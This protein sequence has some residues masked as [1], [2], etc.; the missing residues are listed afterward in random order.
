MT[1]YGTQIHYFDHSLC[2][3]LNLLERPLPDNYTCFNAEYVAWETQSFLTMAK[4]MLK[5][6]VERTRLLVKCRAMETAM[7]QTDHFG[8][9]SFALLRQRLDGLRYKLSGECHQ[10]VDNLLLELSRLLNLNLTEEEYLQKWNQLKLRAS[11]FPS[12]VMPLVENELIDFYESQSP[13]EPTLIR[14]VLTTEDHDNLI[15]R[16][17]QYYCKRAGKEQ[18]VKVHDN[19]KKSQKPVEAQPRELMTFTLRGITD[20]HLTLLFMYMQ[21]EGWIKGTVGDF[22]ALFSGRRENVRLIWTGEMGKS[23]LEYLFQLMCNAPKGITL[24]K[25][26]TLTAILQGHFTDAQGEFLTGLGKGHLPNVKAAPIV[27]EWIDML[28]MGPDELMYYAKERLHDNRDDDMKRDVLE[29]FDI[30]DSVYDSF[31]HQDMNLHRR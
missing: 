19:L 26:Y 1:G 28:Q 29:E 7:V 2:E 5:Q 14:R 6:M 22:K 16:F 18:I 15:L 11:R 23:T 31:N 13:D 30:Y 25:G 9:N 4:E 24:P 10:L 27:K 17:M 20:G 12:G 21:G 8:L 3:L